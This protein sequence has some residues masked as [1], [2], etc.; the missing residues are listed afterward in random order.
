MPVY[1]LE[2]N[3]WKAY[4]NPSRLAAKDKLCYI[5]ITVPYAALLRVIQGDCIKVCKLYLEKGENSAV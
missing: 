2:S 4:K 3:D 1:I 5:A